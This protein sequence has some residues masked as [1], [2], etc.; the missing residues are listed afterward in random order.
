MLRCC[1]LQPCSPSTSKA[2]LQIGWSVSQRPRQIHDRRIHCRPVCL[3][4]PRRPRRAHLAGP[5]GW[6]GFARWAGWRGFRWLATNAPKTTIEN[7]QLRH[8]T[9]IASAMRCRHHQTRT[10]WLLKMSNMGGGRGAGVAGGIAEGLHCRGES[11]GGVANTARKHVCANSRYRKD[12][13]SY[14]C[15]PIFDLTHAKDCR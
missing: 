15:R 7:A 4:R 3:R 1:D 6:L 8:Y 9:A 13:F 11:C 10:S 14:H 5:A 12:W 2:S